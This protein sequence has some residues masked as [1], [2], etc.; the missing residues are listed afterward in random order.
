M[1]VKVQFRIKRVKWKKEM[2]VKMGEGVILYCVDELED[3][4]L[5][6]TLLQ[7]KSLIR[8]L[9]CCCFMAQSAEINHPSYL[10]QQMTP[11]MFCVFSG[12]WV[13]MRKKQQNE[14]FEGKRCSS[15][16]WH[17]RA[18]VCVISLQSLWTRIPASRSCKC[19]SPHLTLSPSLSLK[20]WILPKATLTLGCCL[21]L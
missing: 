1:E 15:S 10:P 2:E 7:N 19:T 9:G 5:L 20:P 18:G 6:W 13:L 17:S 3:Y 11:I 21:L 12:T 4:W 14:S 8:T 16:L